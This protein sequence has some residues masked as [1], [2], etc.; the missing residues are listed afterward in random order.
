MLVDPG[1]GVIRTERR[2]HRTP[3]QVSGIPLWFGDTLSC[4][5]GND[6]RES[7]VDA[8]YMCSSELCVRRGNFT[9]RFQTVRA[10]VN[11]RWYADI[12]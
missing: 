7:I 5:E 8:F 10:A 1:L 6:R 4:A 2:R 9:G 12:R 3:W 11:G